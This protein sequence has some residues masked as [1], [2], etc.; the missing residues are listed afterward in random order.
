MVCIDEA[1]LASQSQTTTTVLLARRPIQVLSP[2]LLVHTW[3]SLTLYSHSDLIFLFVFQLSSAPPHQSMPHW[4]LLLPS[5]AVLMLLES[6][7]SGSLM[8]HR[9][10]SWINLIYPVLRMEE[11][12]FCKSQ[13]QKSTTTQLWSVKLSF[14]ISKLVI[15]LFWEYKVCFACERMLC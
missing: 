6:D 2:F 14:V 15:Q 7:L 3:E 9:C 4:V 12:T 8:G 10:R 1:W 13:L 5:I 11:H